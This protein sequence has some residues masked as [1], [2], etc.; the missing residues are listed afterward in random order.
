LQKTLE[1][2]SAPL[3]RGR[4]VQEKAELQIP[5]SVQAVRDKLLE[6]AAR[7]VNRYNKQHVHAA[8][9]AKTASLLV[10]CGA[11]AAWAY[12]FNKQVRD[13]VVYGFKAQAL[14]ILKIL[15]NE[16]GEFA[17]RHVANLASEKRYH[18]TLILC[19]RCAENAIDKSI[20]RITNWRSPAGMPVIASSPHFLNN[21]YDVVIV[22]NATPRLIGIAQK[23]AWTSW[24]AKAA[25][26]GTSTFFH[27]EQVQKCT[28]NNI[29]AD[30][31]RDSPFV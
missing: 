19:D 18:S 24:L 6:L 20:V 31:M 5:K 2:P 26:S 1:H 17:A 28:Y 3:G 9:F 21:S 27:N 14:N 10:E 25:S 22:F 15:P 12:L 8:Y 7:T 16:E 13:H 11:G 29:A 23:A 4:A 30:S